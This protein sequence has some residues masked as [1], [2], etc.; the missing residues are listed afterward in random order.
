[1]SIE[2][3]VLDVDGTL[4]D[5]RIIYDEQGNELKEFDVKDGLAIAS[6]LKLG[7]EVAI[8]TGR[9]SRIVEKRAKELYI[10]HVFQG[11]EDKLKTLQS[12]LE[13]IGID[14]QQVAVI[15]DDLNDLQMMRFAKLSFMPGD[16]SLYLEEYA[17][18]ILSNNGGR[19]AV[20]EM[21]EYLIQKEALQQQFLELWL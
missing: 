16:G 12:L 3:I 1:M 9:E 7:K 21:I 18:V 20:R 2:L 11:V 17:D 6:W 19:G 15:G 10:K 5:G 13:T 4:T 8:I 14:A